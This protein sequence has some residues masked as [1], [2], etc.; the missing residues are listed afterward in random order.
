MKNPPPLKMAKSK[1]RGMFALVLRFV[2]VAV[3]LN[4]THESIDFRS[5]TE[6]NV[7]TT[8]IK[9]ILEDAG[10]RSLNHLFKS[11]PQLQK[12]YPLFYNALWRLN[13]FRTKFFPSSSQMRPPA[14]RYMNRLTGARFKKKLCCLYNKYINC[15]VVYAIDP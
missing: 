15:Y 13:C 5:E 8:Y 1:G 4:V 11:S 9:V 7:L 14:L 2:T 12:H 10:L 6:A 3:Y